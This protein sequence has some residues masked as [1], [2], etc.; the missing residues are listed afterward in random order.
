MPA[1]IPI[2]AAAMVATTAYTV[3]SGERSAS[4]QKSARKEQEQMQ[5]QSLAQQQ[6]TN[7]QQEQIQR[8]AIVSQEASAAETARLQKE[9]LALQERQA[10]DTRKMQA[11]EAIRMKQVEERQQA[12]MNK[13][14]SRAPDSASLISQAQQK[15]KVGGAGTMLT[16]PMGVDPQ[17][18]T[19]G[20][21]T[22]LG[23]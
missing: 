15:S 10:V 23:G 14:T 17:S 22:L 13:S 7:V 8:E 4:A 6:Q 18:L 5:E 12:D 9:A 11:D 19:L 1:A 21:S 20:K 2:M 3:Y 16:G